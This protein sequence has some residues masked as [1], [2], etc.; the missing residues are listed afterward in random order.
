[1]NEKNVMRSGMMADSHGLEQEQ[2]IVF[3]GT[4]SHFEILSIVPLSNMFKHFW[5]EGC[6]KKLK[7]TFTN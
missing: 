4:V 6:K 3:K 2:A 1:M 7:L 5:G